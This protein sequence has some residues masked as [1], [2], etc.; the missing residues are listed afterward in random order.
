MLPETVVY[1]LCG[2]QLQV[3]RVTDSWILT[4]CKVQLGYKDNNRAY[5]YFLYISLLY[6]VS[7][8]HASHFFILFGKYYF[9]GK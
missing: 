9:L 3:N 6:S 7:K 8:V 1:D 4:D 5:T 2:N